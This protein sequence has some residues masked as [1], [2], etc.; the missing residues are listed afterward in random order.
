[1]YCMRKKRIKKKYILGTALAAFIVLIVITAINW[2]KSKND[3]IFDY[4]VGFGFSYLIIWGFAA[5]L[6]LPVLMLMKKPH[7]VQI[8]Q[9]KEKYIEELEEKKETRKTLPGQQNNSEKTAC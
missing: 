3:T 9:E 8:R 4:I 7:K 1:M 5:I 6:L 2:G